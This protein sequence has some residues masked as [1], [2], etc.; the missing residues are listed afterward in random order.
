VE[1]CDHDDRAIADLAIQI[2]ELGSRTGQTL[3]SR[4]K[5]AD[6]ATKRTIL[7]ITTEK[8]VSNQQSLHITTKKPFD[9]LS[10]GS[11]RKWRQ[12]DSNP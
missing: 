9:L 7:E 10:N 2:L 1:S 8:A 11:L 6:F 4:W 3:T 5:T 12:G